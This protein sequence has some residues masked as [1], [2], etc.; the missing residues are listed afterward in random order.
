VVERDATIMP[1]RAIRASR[2]AARL[3]RHA[4]VIEAWL[5]AMKADRGMA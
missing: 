5:G 1:K 3:H 2:R 4:A